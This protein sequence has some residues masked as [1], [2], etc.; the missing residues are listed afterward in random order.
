MQG[1]TA[2]HPDWG[3][4]WRQQDFDMVQSQ[5]F[6]QFLKDQNFTLINWR[7]AAKAFAQ[8]AKSH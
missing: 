8:H 4:A 7:E 3:A 6:R 2:D 5:E 1:A